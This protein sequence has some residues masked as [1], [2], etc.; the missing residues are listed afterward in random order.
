M[1]DINKSPNIMN[2]IDIENILQNLKKSR[3][4]LELV[5][6]GLNNYLEMK[7]LNFP[8][9]FFLSNDELLEILSETKDPKRVQPHL[10]K[11]FEGIAS[12]VF[13][14]KLD[15]VSMVSSEQEIVELSLIINTAKA[16]GQVEKW[17]VDLEES[18]K[19]TI[20]S[21]IEK[22]LVAYRQTV[23]QDWV[24]QWPGQVVLAVSSTYWTTEMVQAIRQYPNGLSTYLDKCNWQIEK[25]IKLVRGVLPVQ[26]RLTLGIKKYLQKLLR[27]GLLKRIIITDPNKTGALIV[28]DV[29]AKDV[30]VD[31]ANKNIRKTNDFGWI[32]QLRYYWMV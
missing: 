1:K 9:F 31:L 21:V 30:V 12:L 26:T 10:K 22:A 5:Q 14:E 7:R 4:L 29:H 6:K 24:V 18:M 16:K 3:D 17:L 19:T 25:I 11:C 32:S 27:A 8:R 15:V 2:S 23:R 28:I 20:H 13:T